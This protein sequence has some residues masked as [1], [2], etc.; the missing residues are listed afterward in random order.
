MNK[1]LLKAAGQF[2]PRQSIQTIT[3]LGNGLINDTFLVETASDSFVLQRIN[4]GVF[5]QPQ[6]VIHNLAKLNRHIRQKPRDSVKLSIP[7]LLLTQAGRPFYQDDEQQVWR[8]L[9]LIQPAESREQI[10]IDTEAAQVGFALAHFH[11]LCSD[12]PADS[13]HDTLPGF[14][15][16]PSYFQRYRQLLA[17]PLTV[18]KD[19][20]FLKCEVFIHAH[21]NR[22][23][24]LELA[25]RRG[26]LPIRVIHGDP[27]LNNFLFLPGSEQII[28][29]IDLDTVKP[30]LLH[31]DIGD[32]IRS[33][34]RNKQ[35]NSFNLAHCQI[36]LQHYL[37]EAGDFFTASD[38]DYL[39][40]AIWLIPFELGLRFFSDYLAGN[41]YFKVSEPKQNLVRALGQFTFC[42]SIHN[43]QESLFSCIQA[44]KNSYRV[45]T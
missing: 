16:T 8:S 13:L 27:K 32:C 21:H 12:L 45:K 39:Y 2:T 35:D 40:A 7:E 28:S 34:C 10:H 19:P 3:P 38:Y 11:R 29:L 17:E 44:L 33:C 43:Q 9:E 42:E 6:L 41:P 5:P 1:T 31:Y 25:K 22:L 15:I 20:A 18:E 23:D 24:V 4:A 30:G 14:H 36:I 37:Q 26:A